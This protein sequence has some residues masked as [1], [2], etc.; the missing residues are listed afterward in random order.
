[1]LFVH[2]LS[3]KIRLL[4]FICRFIFFADDHSR[5]YQQTCEQMGGTCLQVP[6]VQTGG[7]DT[8]CDLNTNIYKDYLCPPTTTTQVCCIPRHTACTNT[9]G[10]CTTDADTCFSVGNFFSWFNCD[11]G[12][13]TVGRCCIP[14]KKKTI[15][16]FVKGHASGHASLADSI[17]DKFEGHSKGYNKHDLSHHGTGDSAQYHHGYDTNP[18]YHGADYSTSPGN[19][20]RGYGGSTK[21]HGIKGHISSSRKHG[22][23]GHGSGY[24]SAHTN[25]DVGYGSAPAN[26]D[27]G[28][29]IAS[30]KHG[31]SYGSPFLGHDTAT[32]GSSK[33]KYDSDYNQHGADYNGRHDGY[34]DGG[35]SQGRHTGHGGYPDRFSRDLSSYIYRTLQH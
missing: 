1:M 13:D 30:T 3:V 2:F 18:S 22:S 25:H 4:V 5:G 21:H 33:H 15:K 20:G 7:D 35:Y 6:D 16:V 28:Y 10:T 32:S 19:H 34:G 23:S 29:G 26:H 17:L 8:I 27:I 11:L 12:D 24:G 14:R 31:D 9:G